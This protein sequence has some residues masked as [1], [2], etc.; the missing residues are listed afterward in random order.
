MGPNPLGGWFFKGILLFL[1]G[2]V[3]GVGALQTVSRIRERERVKATRQR[4][5]AVYAQISP[6]VEVEL[7]V[8]EDVKTDWNYPNKLRPED[9]PR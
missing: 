3:F 4:A 2:A 1:A 9:N 8:S 5:E 7:T 6:Q